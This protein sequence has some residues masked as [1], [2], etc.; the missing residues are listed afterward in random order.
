MAKKKAVTK[1]SPAKKKTAVAKKKLPAKAKKPTAKKKA[2]AKKKA[3]VKKPATKKPIAKKSAAKKA[4]VKKKPAAKKKA[5]PAKTKSTAKST[6]A[7]AKP[8]RAAKKAAA[9]KAPVKKRIMTAKKRPNVLSPTISSPLLSKRMTKTGKPKKLPAAFLRKQKQKLL[10]LHDTLIGQM[11]GITRDTL[12]SAAD[13]GDSSAFGMHQA[14]AGTDAYDREFAL[15]LLSQEQDAV[16][17][18]EEA[19]DRIELGSYGICEGSGDPIPQARLEAMPFARCTVAYQEML[20]Q[21]NSLGIH[22]GPA[23]SLFGTE[24]DVAGR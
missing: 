21:D 13:G 2:V 18:I 3:T 7:K 11:N 5:A 17:E 10:E 24:S 20:D 4:P 22:R 6:R 12:T 8:A 1:K 19:L 14:D 9:R 23:E 15:N 16:H